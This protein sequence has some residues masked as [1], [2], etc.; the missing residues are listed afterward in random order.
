M[1]AVITAL[2]SGIVSWLVSVL[3]ASPFSSITSAGLGDWTQ[4]L[5]WLNWL[6]PISDCLTLFTAWLSLVLV[7]VVARFVVNKIV[8]PFFTSKIGG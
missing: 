5:G 6:L 1:I 4:Y 3:P 8:L 7:Y 2:L